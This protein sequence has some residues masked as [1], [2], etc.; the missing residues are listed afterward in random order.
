M[1]QNRT[2]PR[3]QHRPQNRSQNRSNEWGR[4][5]ELMKVPWSSCAEAEERSSQIDRQLGFRIDVCEAKVREFLESDERQQ[6]SDLSA[7]LFQTS[8]PELV[9]IVRLFK[10]EKPLRWLDLGA[11]YGRLG[12]V[13][14]FLRPKDFFYGFEFVSERV[15]HGSEVLMSWN[16][17]HASLEQQDLLEPDFQLPAFDVVFIFDFGASAQI[18]QIL[19][20]LHERSK[21]KL[22]TVI[23]RGPVTRHLIATQHAWLTQS[24]ELLRSEHWM[25]Y[26]SSN[27]SVL[28]VLS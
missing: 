4:I 24:E 2:Q 16:C 23:G 28:P 5:G 15:E 26:H 25:L 22:V 9:A 27:Q 10:G 6:Q 19:D 21:T 7:Q 12:F 8:Y 3:P 18:S 14:A 17:L 1:R 20:Q 13:L 11:A